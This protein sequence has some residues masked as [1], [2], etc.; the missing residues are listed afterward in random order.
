[1]RIAYIAAGAGGMYCGSCIHD[2]TLAAALLRR[3]EDVAL[4]PTY[5]PI[6]TDEE[7]VSG[8]RVF[9]GALNVYLEQKSS[10]FR[11]TPRA[12]AWLLDRP[13]LLKQVSKLGS[14]TDARDLGDLALGVLEGESGPQARELDKL[15][16]WLRDHYRPDIVHITN[17]MSLGLVRRLKEELQVP[18]AVA[19][20]GEDLFIDQLHE[21]F[22]SAVVAEMR[23]RAAEADLFV[24]PSR[25]YA[26]HMAE[27]LAVPMDRMRVVPLGI[28]L[29]G[30]DTPPDRRSD[31]TTIGYLARICPEKGLHLLVD[32]FVELAVRPEYS[33]LRLRIAGYLGPRDR[34][35]FE[36]CLAKID[37]AGLTDRVDPVGEVDLAGKMA[38]LSSLDILSV[39]T[40]YHEPKGLYVLEAMASGVP[41]VQ[42]AHGSF[43]EMIEA[44]GGG[45]LVE[46]GSTRALVDGL[47][48]LL[49]EPALRERH[50][51]AARRAVR[52]RFND[53]AMAAT[54]MA[55]YREALS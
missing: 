16:A 18:V 12:L 11:H 23:R 14:S 9:Y 53:D 36:E 15:V 37:K 41:V 49:D 28:R 52:E 27:M 40:V 24:S 48:R 33:G 6:R 30:H 5:T 39:P 34:P 19:V 20:Q 38:F 42:P 47:R 45:L 13:W 1:M 32:A 50:G 46:P 17:S 8:S 44:T 54:M 35:F 43:P 7:S 55:V 10:I 4:L 3:G 22:H 21:P 51:I 2:N 31:A 25:Y 29:E 26:E